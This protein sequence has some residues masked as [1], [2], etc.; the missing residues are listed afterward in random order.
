LAEQRRE[1]GGNAG[2]IHHS[3]GTPSLPVAEREV[4]T[5]VLLQHPKSYFV[6]QSISQYS[7]KE[8][9]EGQ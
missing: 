8:R 9:R 5:V 1:F 2:K 6:N 4:K 7:K 3:P